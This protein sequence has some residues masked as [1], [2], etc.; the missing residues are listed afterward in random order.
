MTEAIDIVMDE[1]LSVPDHTQSSRD[2][3]TKSSRQFTSS[4]VNVRTERNPTVRKTMAS[5]GHTG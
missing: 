5:P 4:K 3:E 1:K 2:V